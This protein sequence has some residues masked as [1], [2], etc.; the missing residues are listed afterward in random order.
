MIAVNEYVSSLDRANAVAGEWVTLKRMEPGTSPP[1]YRAVSCRATVRGVRP[2]EVIGTIKLT[3]VRIIM[4]PTEISRA[5][6]PGLATGK[7]ADKSV[8]MINDKVVVKGREM[9]I[10][11]ADIIYVG[12]AW[13]RANL[14]ASG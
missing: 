10:S 7:P 12:D 1:I 4:S 5:G 9:Q 11:F 8:P 14:I 13:V 2:E 6:W 3:D